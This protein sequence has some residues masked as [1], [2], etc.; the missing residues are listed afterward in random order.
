MTRFVVERRIA[1]PPDAVFGFLTRADQ[2]TR[3]QGTAAELDPRPGGV[4]RVDVRD[5]AVTSGV[6][7]E[8]TPPHRVS[9]TWGF[10]TPGHPIPPGST[11]VEIDLLP[12]AG[13]TVLRLTHSAVPPPGLEVR[14]GWGHWLDRLDSIATGP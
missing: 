12:D 10:E 3:W 11:L 9:F 5:G 4:F 14:Q 6:Y 7:V 13:G 8:V 2:W 1:V